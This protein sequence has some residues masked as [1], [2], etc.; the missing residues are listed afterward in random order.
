MS[1]CTY[2]EQP[3]LGWLRS[4]PDFLYRQ[5]CKIATRAEEIAGRPRQTL[6][7]FLLARLA[8][9]AAQLGNTLGVIRHPQ[10][11]LGL[12]ELE[13]N[14]PDGGG[15]RHARGSPIPA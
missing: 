14:L 11:L 9:H 12:V 4:S 15:V 10:A 8:E 1:E 6:R 5:L 3:I 7:Q 2:V 13:F